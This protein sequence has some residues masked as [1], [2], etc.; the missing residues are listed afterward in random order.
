ML[1]NEDKIND[2]IIENI[3]SWRHTGA[4]LHIGG[5][6]LP[7][8]E[9]ALGNLAKYIVRAVFSQELMIYIPAEKSADGSANVL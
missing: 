5:R 8:Y 7:E 3:L 1:K 2:S 4:C 9:T 6:I